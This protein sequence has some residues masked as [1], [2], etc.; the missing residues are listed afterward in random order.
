MLVSQEA[1]TL[2]L[3]VALLAEPH[4]GQHQPTDQ[5]NAGLCERD[6]ESQGG[7]EAFGSQVNTA[8]TLS[9]HT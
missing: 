1:V 2:L 8:V 5:A 9:V 4:A 3:S 7:P 6:S